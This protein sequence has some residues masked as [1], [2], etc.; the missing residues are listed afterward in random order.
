MKRHFADWIDAYLEFTNNTEPC[1]MYRRWCAISCVAAVLQRKCWLEW[2]KKYYPNMYIV[3][4]SPPGAGRKGT[5]MGPIKPFLRELGIPIT[6]NSITSAQL[7][8]SINR[9]KSVVR[10]GDDD[11]VTEHHSITV[12]SEEFTVFLGYN[13]LDLMTYLI[14]WFDTPEGNW[15]RETSTQGQ[16]SIQNIWVNILGATTTDFMRRS[17]TAESAGGGFLSRVVF[18]YANKRGKLVP[19]P[20]LMKVDGKWVKAPNIYSPDDPFRMK[21]TD[22][23]RMIHTMSGE[24]IVT[25]EFLES[26]IP[27]YM[28]LDNERA[29][30]TG[31]LASFSERRQV[32]LLKL[33]MILSASRSSERVITGEDFRRAHVYM[34]EAEAVMPKVFLGFGE[35]DN[36]YAIQNIMTTIALK[37]QIHFGELLNKHLSDVGSQEDLLKIV[38]TL[39]LLKPPFC[40][41][42]QKTMMI[43]YLDVEQ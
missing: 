27:W 12:F 32:H 5:A 29:K 41:F 3:L 18:I 16:Y 7:I 40:S 1:E 20:H 24:F 8:K 13:Q 2:G 6:A 42:D 26:Y 34:S 30:F 23:L 28:N 36:A 15:T 25:P 37:K 21:L 35:A 33:C 4:V 43:T 22:D 39:V 19:T 38:R 31:P 14:D 10:L 17:M 9:A 11:V